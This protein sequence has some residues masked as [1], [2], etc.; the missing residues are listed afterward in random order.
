[1]VTFVDDQEFQPV[2]PLRARPLVV[3]EH[4]LVGDDG[5]FPRCVQVEADAGGVGP[6]VL[7]QSLGPLPPYREAGREYHCPL[8]EA[9]DD[10]Q[11]QT[12]LSGPRRGDDV[13]L[14]VFAVAVQPVEDALL[15]AA[16]GVAEGEGGERHEGQVRQ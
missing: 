4:G 3:G 10:L 13:D 7:H 1:M 9:A 5:Q 16:P 14:A 15:V 12:R 8:S 2:Q 11:P 6:E